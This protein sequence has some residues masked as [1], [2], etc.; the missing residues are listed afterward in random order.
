[1]KTLKIQEILRTS[2][3][4]HAID[5]LCLVHKVSDGLVLLKYKQIESDFSLE[6]V[7]ECRGIILDSN[8]N[9]NIVSYPYDK[10]FNLGEGNCAPI[11]WDIA[12]F[13]AKLDGSLVNFYYYKD[14]W[15]VQTSGTINADAFTSEPSKTFNEVIWETVDE[16][17]GREKFLSMLDTNC[18]Y[19]FELCTPYNIVVTQHIDSKLYLHG[20]RDMK[21]FEWLD[22][23]NSEL[24]KADRYD[25]KHIDDMLARFEHMTWQEEGFVVF[26]GINR[27]KCKNPKYVEVHHVATGVS[28]FSIINVVKTNEVDEYLS[29]FTQQADVVRMYERKWKELNYQLDLQFQTL[30]TIEDQKAFALAVMADVPKPYHG[31]FFCARNG[32]TA[33]INE[34]LR[35]IEHRYFYYLFN[36]QMNM[37]T[38]KNKL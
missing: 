18:N 34:G 20:I 16:M 2:G 14:E 27:A 28:P 21:T 12:K 4:Q 24:L 36:D 17:Y 13:Y 7:R 19:M 26:D 31:A 6:A 25:L 1:M 35:N 30:N 5:T 33:S 38:N 15:K 3:L 29:Y 37:Y 32:K 22:I 10:F 23:D 11:N 8:D 9:W